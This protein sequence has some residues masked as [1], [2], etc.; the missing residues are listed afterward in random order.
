VSQGHFKDISDGLSNTILVRELA[1]APLCYEGHREVEQL[2]LN[3]GGPSGA[4]CPRMAG[5]WI[6]GESVAHVGLI[7]ETQSPFGTY[8]ANDDNGADEAFFSF[9]PG[10]SNVAMCDGSVRAVR[11]G[12][13]GDV[14][15]ALFT[16]EAGDVLR[17]WE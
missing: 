1:G 11:S 3:H 2:E 4:N 6:S 15:V 10:V 7:V 17:D 5:P 14:V 9:H 13:A 16:R 12:I 8:N